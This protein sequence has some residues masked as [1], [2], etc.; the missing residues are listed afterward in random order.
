M[1][2][3]TIDDII[4]YRLY[5]ILIQLA[6]FSMC[7]GSFSIYMYR[8]YIPVNQY[9]STTDYVSNYICTCSY[10]HAYIAI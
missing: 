4:E 9:P 7:I 10:M 6:I 1:Q 2:Y 5:N 3:V 8:L